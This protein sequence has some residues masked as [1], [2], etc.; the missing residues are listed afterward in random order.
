MRL[1]PHLLTNEAASHTGRQG[2]VSEILVCRMG[3]TLRKA[4]V[5]NLQGTFKGGVTV[6]SRN[7]MRGLLLALLSSN[8]CL[9]K[10]KKTNPALPLSC[11][12]LVCIH[13]A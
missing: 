8:Q 12:C 4:S 2:I 9:R 3:L 5:S 11:K 6:C 13:A 10:K 7:I 1:R